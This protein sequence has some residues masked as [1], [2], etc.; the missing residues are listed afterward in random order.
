MGWEQRNGSNY[1]YRKERSGVRV[2]SVYVGNGLVADLAAQMDVVERSKREAERGAL[3][4]EIENQEAI[5]SLINE[6]CSM[7]E[8]LTRA[9]L[10]ASGFHLHKGQWRLKRNAKEES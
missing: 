6:V 1:Y 3:H 2:R 7:T 8:R 4:H 9:A 5:D 10:I